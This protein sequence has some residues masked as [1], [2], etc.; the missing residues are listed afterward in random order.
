M[1]DI[2]STDNPTEHSVEQAP[3]KVNSNLRD[4]VFN[5]LKNA[6]LI[7]YGQRI[8]LAL[9]RE[10]TGV[11][12]PSVVGLPFSQAKHKI[13]ADNLF[14]LGLRDQIFEKYLMR[15]GMALKQNGDHWVIPSKKEMHKV[16]QSYANKASNA[17]SRA[18]WLIKTAP[19]P[20]GEDM[21]FAQ[22]QAARVARQV[23]KLTEQAARV[24]T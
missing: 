15:K 14:F 23:A 18:R 5:K 17:L 24:S 3:A 1:F 20:S 6:G 22:A 16:W 19:T 7:G 4:E 12:E 2:S 10:M 9:I 21:A 8:P 13:D 11:E